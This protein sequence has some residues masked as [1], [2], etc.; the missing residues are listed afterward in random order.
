M[1]NKYIERRLLALRI[2]SARLRFSEEIANDEIT[3]ED[4][5]WL[6]KQ[7]SSFGTEQVSDSK[8][9]IL[10]EI[11][12][13]PFLLC[14]QPQLDT[15]IRELLP[16]I[17]ETRYVQ[18]VEELKQM[19]NLGYIDKEEEKGQKQLLKFCYYYTS[20]EG[21]YILRRKHVKNSVNDTIEKNKVIK[22]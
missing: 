13:S 9:K 1:E 11:F 8:Q 14:D 6:L 5:V 19:R 16:N 22:L 4:I 18:E 20:E 10:R 21:Q 15:S 12:N 17:L 7:N 2:Q 3:T